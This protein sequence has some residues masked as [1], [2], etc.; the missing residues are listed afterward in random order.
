MKRTANND[1][2]VTAGNGTAETTN[3]VAEPSHPGAPNPQASGHWNVA[4]L[5]ILAAGI[6][7][8]FLALG[9]QSFEWD[10]IESVTMRWRGVDAGLLTVI[11][12]PRGPLYLVLLKGWMSVF[13]QGDGAVRT[14]SALLGSVGLVLFYRAALIT[15]GRTAA[16]VGL[17]LL[18]VSPFH[19]WYSQWARNYVL[20]FDLG[21]LAVPAFLTDVQRRTRGTFL[22]TL[23]TTVGACLANLAGLFLFVIYGVYALAFGRR[24]HYPIVRLIVLVALAGAILWPWGI[25]ALGVTGELHLG[26]P[27]ESSGKLISKG[28]SPPGLLS[29]PFTFYNFS[30]G[31]SV[32]PSITE[33][34]IHRLPAVIPHLWYLIPAGILFGLTTLLG[35]RRADRSALPVIAIWLVIPVILMAALSMLNL[36]APNARYAFL[37][38]APYLLLIAVGVISIGNR[39]LR[40]G[41]LAA[42]LLFSLYSDYNYFTNPRYWRPDARAAGELLTRHVRPDDAVIFYA[43]DYPKYYVRTEINNLKLTRKYLAG[44][45]AMELWLRSNTENKNRIWVVQCFG[46][47][48]DEDDRFLHLCQR[49]MIPAGE[50]QFKWLPVYL[51]VKPS[52]W[53]SQDGRVEPPRESHR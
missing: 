9:Q 18:A 15:V 23:I 12:D 13:G 21:V 36:K 46:W 14:L 51:F 45:Q 8:R 50:W 35:L 4:V 39:V 49:T 2:D 20:F 41:L 25:K 30:L 52:D 43:M 19:L 6:I 5:L 28:D 24:A 42:L 1:A 29:V 11:M 44:E 47:W 32:G 31:Y 40:T 34:K 26:R 38:F 7:L 22:A 27:A 17:A 10:E 53:E 16:V 37:A 3:V 33:L 48:I